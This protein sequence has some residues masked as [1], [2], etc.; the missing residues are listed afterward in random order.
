MKPIMVSSLLS[1]YFMPRT[2]M[3]APHGL[4]ISYLPSQQSYKAIIHPNLHMNKV[5]PRQVTQLVR[6]H[7]TEGAKQAASL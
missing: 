7:V 5:R 3:S 2:V 6:D 4:I 1:P